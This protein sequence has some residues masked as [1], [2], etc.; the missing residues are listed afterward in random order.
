MAVDVSITTYDDADIAF[1]ASQ[2]PAL[3]RAVQRRRV[4]L[5]TYRANFSQDPAF[6]LAVLA[7]DNVAWEITSLDVITRQAVDRARMKGLDVQTS[8][9]AG[10]G[11]IPI[12]AL[13]IIAAAAVIAIIG[14]GVFGVSS[15]IDHYGRMQE[16]LKTADTQMAILRAE[17]GLP[18][19]A[20]EPVPTSAADAAKSVAGSLTT[21]A[22]V[23]LAIFALSKFTRRRAV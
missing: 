6:N 7:L 8:E 13:I 2:L 19:V 17:A 12:A 15:W 22:L 5:E 11:F 3:G 14:I 16:H 10:L 20:P 23:A 9:Q 1:Q 4:E 18:A 21:V